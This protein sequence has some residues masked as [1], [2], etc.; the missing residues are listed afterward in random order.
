LVT[1][2]AAVDVSE[3]LLEAVTMVIVT[4]SGDRRCKLRPYD[5]A[6]CTLVYL[7]KHDTLAQ[8]AAGF[9]VSI[10]TVFRYIRDTTDL[11]AGF[12]PDLKEALTSTDP[13]GYLLLD[14]TVAEMDRTQEEDHFSGKVKRSGVN[15]Q[16]VTNH[17][18][19]ILWLSPA[20]PG[21]VNDVKAARTHRI[22]EICEELGF[23]VLADLGYVG[24]GGTV[25][26]P[27]KRAPKME[28]SDKHKASNRVHA[29]LRAPVER[30]FAKIK[31]WR[32]LRHARLS[33]NRLTAVAAAILTLTIYT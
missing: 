3:E 7:R 10:A 12:A 33:P 9:R 26:T 25:I 4:R 14:G 6:L 31:N 20:L 19:K 2:P 8:I 21:A 5:R 16:L 22:M 24:A 32:I 13:G 17:A 30:G 29:G 23:E 28:L 15:L 27:I 11:L 1:Y 18:G